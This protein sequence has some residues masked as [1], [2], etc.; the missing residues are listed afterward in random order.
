MNKLVKTT[1]LLGLLAGTFALS[2]CIFAIGGSEPKP[3]PAKGG[4]TLGQELVDLQKA[5]DS[6]AITEA[7]YE[8]QRGKLL[9]TGK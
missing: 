5:R 6:G 2:G 4:T 3:A 7:E 1:A 8:T 9:G